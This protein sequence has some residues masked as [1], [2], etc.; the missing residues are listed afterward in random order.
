MS[1]RKKF[2]KLLKEQGLDLTTKEKEELSGLLFS[3]LNSK[4]MFKDESLN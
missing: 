4:N 3:F 2:G 1:K